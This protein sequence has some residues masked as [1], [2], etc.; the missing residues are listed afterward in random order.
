MQNILGWI[1]I[2]IFYYIMYGLFDGMDF[3]P[4]RRRYP[5]TRLYS[6]NPKYYS[7]VVW[8]VCYKVWNWFCKELKPYSI[9]DASAEFWFIVI[10]L[11]WFGGMYCVHIIPEDMSS[12]NGDTDCY[13]IFKL[14]DSV[15][16]TRWDTKSPCQKSEWTQRTFL[17]QGWLFKLCFALRNISDGQH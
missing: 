3:V 12:S 10:M 15:L 8:K 5:L 17:P 13:I 6:V 4:W 2:M 14:L 1:W 16:Y 11:Y 9:C 7:L